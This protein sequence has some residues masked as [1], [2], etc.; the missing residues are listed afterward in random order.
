MPMRVAVSQA[1]NHPE[2][3]KVEKHVDQETMQKQ[4]TKAQI[5]FNG[6]LAERASSL[7]EDKNLSALAQSNY[8]SKLRVFR[9]CQSFKGI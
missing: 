1:A 7:Y 3:L 5:A 9:K 2:L 4:L 6:I 8:C